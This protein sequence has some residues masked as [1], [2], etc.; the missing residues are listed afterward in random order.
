MTA[1]RIPTRSTPFTEPVVDYEPAP[2]GAPSP[3]LCPQPSPAAIHRHTPRALRA[4]PAAPA[5]AVRTPEPPRAA[6]VFAD[7]ALR[8]ILEVA[9]RRRPVAQ[10]RP[11]LAPALFDA[12][13]TLVRTPATQGSAVLRRVRLQPTA[14]V[15]GEATA[16][17]VFATYTRGARVRA[18]AGRVELVAG[19]WT[20]VALQIG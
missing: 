15:D 3:G 12:V 18:I 2:V 13:T 10:L 4:V 11:L 7:T 19:R 16:A 1:A 17:E 20:I 5:P 6:A 14:P 9:D 8:R